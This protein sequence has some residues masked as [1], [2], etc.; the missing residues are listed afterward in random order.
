MEQTTTLVEDA[1]DA[2][3]EAVTQ[4]QKIG[5][6]HLFKGRLSSKWSEL[7][8]HDL[9]IKKN[10]Q[11]RMTVD[12]WGKDLILIIWEF[13]YECWMIRNTVEH[14]AN[15][16]PI[17]AKKEKVILHIEWL[18]KNNKVCKQHSYY[19]MKRKKLNELPLNNLLMMEIQL[20]NLAKT[21]KINV[22]KQQGVEVES[23]DRNEEIES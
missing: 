14:E 5:W 3:Q 19:R 11:T 9:E 22:H 15:T 1:S 23:M 8:N 17:K 21:E 2:L 18:V 10:E 12:K 7:Y 6:E 4:Q 20:N 13:V 16:D